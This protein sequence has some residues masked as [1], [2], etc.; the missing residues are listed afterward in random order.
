[1]KNLD[2]VDI[3][4]LG[5]IGLGFL[6]ALMSY[7]LLAKEQTNKEARPAIL[8]AIKTYMGF[9]LILVLLATVSE[10]V[11]LAYPGQ[12]AQTGHV[13]QAAPAAP[14][15]PDKGVEPTSQKRDVGSRT[16]GSRRS[17]LRTTWRR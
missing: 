6:L 15:S 8:G 10:I 17:T 3:L 16:R 5:A 13:T 11:K 4:R 14:V 1:M 12:A 2:V 9:A 7:R